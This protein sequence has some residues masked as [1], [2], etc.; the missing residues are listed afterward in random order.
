MK[1]RETP[2]VAI[3]VDT[4]TGWGRRMIRGIRNY[5]RKHGPWQLRLE[6]QGQHETFRLPEGWQGDG[7]IARI[8]TH[9]VAR[10]LTNS[11]LPVINVSAIQL[12]GVRFPTVCNNVTA[13]ARLAYQHFRDRGFHSFAYCGFD[14]LAHVQEHRREFERVLAEHGATCATYIPPGRGRRPSNWL[15]RLQQ[16]ADWL[17]V[18]PRPLGI[19]CWGADGGQFVLEACRFGG[20][21]VPS[22]AA[23]LGGDDD[24]LLCTTTLPPMSGILVP[25][26]Q[27]GYEAARMLDEMLHGKKFKHERVILDPV[28]VTTRQSTDTLAIED[29]DVA[30]AIGFIRANSGRPIQVDDILRTVPISRRALERRFERILGRSPS[31]EIRRVRLA[32]AVELLLTTDLPIPDVAARSG[33]NSPQY[34]AR[35]FSEEYELT[36]LK[37]RNKLRGH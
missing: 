6:P 15:D 5:A 7:V 30:S 22:D 32:I 25:S 23:V 4:A 12:R 21:D 13:S 16:M 17:S 28:G 33:F 34:F 27:V 19:F 29:Q 11:G 8:H 26:E 24:E 10:H 9:A 14:H 2:H 31:E 1:K 18:L 20:I 36:P 3:L 35:V 37:Y